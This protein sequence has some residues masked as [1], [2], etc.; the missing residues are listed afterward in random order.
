M[1][2]LRFAA[3]ALAAFAA[4]TM[5]AD[6]SPAPPPAP[7]PVYPKVPVMVAP[8]YDWTGFYIG[9]HVAYSW[10]H[11]NSTTTDIATGVVF[12]PV[13]EDTSH[14]HGGG[15]IGFDYMMPS[16][17]VFGVVADF[18][19]GPSNS[20]TSSNAA[21]T[22]VETNASK[23]DVTGTVRG[24]LG[25]AADALLVYVT[26][27]WLW[28]SG[29]RTRTQVAGAVNAATA[30]TVETLN[31]HNN[32]WVVGGGLD[33][34]FARNWDVFAEYRYASLQAITVTFPLAGRSTT[35]TSTTNTF[36]VGLDYRLNWGGTVAARY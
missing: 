26:G 22:V 13:T 23:T 19:T 11:T 33:Y 6:I 25:Y 5:A 1:Q 10:V 15:Q 34:A 36:E 29:S 28:N 20:T 18:S 16:R 7:A 35:S 24:R 30:G 21:G 32:G 14:F 27:G 8:A 4:P 31:T 9:G 3:L 2:R 17:I 12:A